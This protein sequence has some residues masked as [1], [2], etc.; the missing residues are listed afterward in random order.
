MIE[1]TCFTH[2]AGTFCTCPSG[3]KLKNATFC[4]DVDECAL[5]IGVCTQLCNNTVGGYVCSCHKGYHLLVDDMRTCRAL[6]E[7]PKLLVANRQHIRQIDLRTIWIHAFRCPRIS[8]RRDGASTRLNSADT[9]ARKK[10]T[11]V[12][13]GG[14]APTS[15]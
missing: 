11:V 10:F 4:E 14:G 9:A 3:F 8:R 6:G 2:Y 12:G 5:P 13:V 15:M 7:D 1:H